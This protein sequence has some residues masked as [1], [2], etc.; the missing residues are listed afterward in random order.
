MDCASDVSSIH[1]AD[2]SECSFADGTLKGEQQRIIDLL[3]GQSF[4][5][6][7]LSKA[8]PGWYVGI[9]Q[10]YEKIHAEEST[11]LDKWVERENL[12]EMAKK[13]NLTLCIA[14]FFPRT[15]EERLQILFEKMAWFFAFDDDADSFLRAD[16]FADQQVVP[17]LK[18]WINPERSGPEPIVLPCCYIYRSCGPKLAVGWSEA[19]KEQFMDTTIEYV[20]CLFE[21]SKQRETYLPSIEEYIEGRIINIGVYPTLDLIPFASGIEIPQETLRHE[22][23]QTIRYHV[24]RIVSL[25]NDLF[26]IRKEIKDNQFDNILP[27]L[28]M[29]RGMTMQEAAD[30]TVELI[31]E[32]YRIVNE[33]QK[34][35]PALEGKAK[36]DLAEY[37]EQC[38]DQAT[39]SVWFHELSPRYLGQG[40]Y[41]EQ[42]IRVQL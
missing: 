21:V 17:F 2:P 37:I 11:F 31:K 26:S 28:V 35:L 15:T 10:H 1:S 39:G 27:L 29:R 25:T 38:K 41:G 5:I 8:F 30:Y 12:R 20:N 36:D 32:S 14:C 9:N 4:T 13:V 33:A 6:P 3:K 42:E 22:A 19:S 24:V 18:Y 7:Y 34:R 40:A 16:E 23:V